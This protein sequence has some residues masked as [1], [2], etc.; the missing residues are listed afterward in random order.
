MN[1]MPQQFD[2][3]IQ[4]QTHKTRINSKKKDQNRPKEY[5]VKTKNHS[6]R[7]PLTHTK[8]YASEQNNLQIKMKPTNKLNQSSE[9]LLDTQHL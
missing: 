8:L 2:G 9:K 7:Q 5:T 3:N 6:Q 4:M 1:R